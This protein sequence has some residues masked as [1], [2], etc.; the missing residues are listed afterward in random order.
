[1]AKKYLLTLTS[2]F[3]KNNQRHFIVGLLILALYMSFY[4]FP[5]LT[6][7]LIQD[8]LDGFLPNLK[9]I[10]SSS[11]FFQFNPLMPVEGVLDGLPRG[12]FSSMFYIP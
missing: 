4:C 12:L 2:Y 5:N 6:H 11:H 8:N 1:M 10:T 3:K 9:L 7:I